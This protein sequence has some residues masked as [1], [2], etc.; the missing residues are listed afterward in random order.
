MPDSI[1]LLRKAALRF[2][3][4]MLGIWLLTSPFVI[5]LFRGADRARVATVVLTLAS[6]GFVVWK[7]RRA[8]LSYLREFAFDTLT[9]L[10]VVALTI[11]FSTLLGLM[12]RVNVHR[13]ALLA[14]VA[15]VAC[16]WL[17]EYSEE[18]R[19]LAHKSPPAPG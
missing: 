7:Y 9:A 18:K 19:R 15:I 6:Y 16:F 13:H 14:V 11:A 17:L 3:R 5:F 8:G 1:S 2:L 10:G 12:M 4:A